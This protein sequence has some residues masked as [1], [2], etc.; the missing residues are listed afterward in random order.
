MTP[1][2]PFLARAFLGAD[3]GQRF[4]RCRAATHFLRGFLPTQGRRRWK[5]GCGSAI[6]AAGSRCGPAS[7]S[8]SLR[9]RRI[10]PLERTHTT[11][12]GA[13]APRGTALE[14]GGAPEPAS[15]RPARRSM[16]VAP[17]DY[18]EARDPPTSSRLRGDPPNCTDRRKQGTPGRLMCAAPRP[19]IPTPP[20]LVARA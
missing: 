5:T 19:A 2:P 18:W 4:F 8:V 12:G 14:P 7:W 20:N 9:R 1:A 10:E 13:S 3:P 11:V 16:A 15:R 6:Q 17:R